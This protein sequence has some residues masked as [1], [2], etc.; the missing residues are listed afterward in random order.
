MGLCNAAATFNRVLEQILIGI[1]PEICVLYIDDV[2]VHS[3]TFQGML[4]RL[5]VVLDRIQGAGLK[6]KTDKCS[7][8]SR[9]QNFGRGSG[10]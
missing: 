5:K 4:D 10:T 8:F 2:L 1:P 9:A 6:F 3:A 7:H